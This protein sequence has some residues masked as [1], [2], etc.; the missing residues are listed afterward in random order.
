MV[1]IDTDVAIHWRDGDAAVQ[2]LL[3]SLPMLPAIS[4]ITQVELENGVYRDTTQSARR[5]A[6]LDMLLAKLTVLAFTR[7]TAANFAT[8]VAQRGFSRWRTADRMIAATAIMHDATLVTMNGA[9]YRDVAG[10][11]L[12]VWPVPA[13]S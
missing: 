5:R 11:K 7:E 1:V 3:A 2:T 8:I 10:L 4:V 9:D 6:R 12:T 13:P